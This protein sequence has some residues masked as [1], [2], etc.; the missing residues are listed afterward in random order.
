MKSLFGFLDRLFD[1]PGEKKTQPAGEAAG[2]A[3]KG[4]TPYYPQLAEEYEGVLG[5]L[6][7]NAPGSIQVRQGLSEYMESLDQKVQKLMDNDAEQRAAEKMGGNELSAL[8]N[9]ASAFK[10]IADEDAGQFGLGRLSEEEEQRIGE[11]RKELKAFEEKAQGDIQE[12]IQAVSAMLEGM[13]VA[14]ETDYVMR[15]VF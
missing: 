4:P 2:K 3:V 10:R 11:Y 6:R 13:Q 8:I 7:N 9:M 14:L 1:G 15:R 12:K 5:I